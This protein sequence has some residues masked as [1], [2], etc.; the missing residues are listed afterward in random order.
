M[1]L[2]K[3]DAPEAVQDAQ[4]ASQLPKPSGYRLLLAMPGVKEKTDGG[5]LLSDSH[6]HQEQVAATVGF[7]VS[8]GPDAYKDSA[9]FPNGPWCKE[10][11]WVICRTYSGTRVKIHGQEF[12]FV[13]DDTI[14]G[15][16]EDPRGVERA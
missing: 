13:N 16:V 15:V 2:Y 14:D 6:K 1:N 4:K 11:D 12:R 9:K 7:V 3:A 10:G 8:M 5:I